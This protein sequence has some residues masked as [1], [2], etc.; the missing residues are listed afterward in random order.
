MDGSQCDSSSTFPVL[1]VEDN[2]PI[3]SLLQNALEGAGH[4]SLCVTNGPDALA[5]LEQGY[6]PIV[7]TDLVV[8]GMD[9]LELCR[10]IRER[11]Q[12][13]YIYII[14]LTARGSREDLI[15]GLEAGADEYLVKPLG[16]AELRARLKI[17]RR[18][19]D[20]ESSLKKSLEEFKNL[21][22]KDS[23]TGFFNRRYLAER[24]P[25]EIRRAV[26]YGRPLSLLLFDLDHFK[27]VND[28][29]GH[30]VGDLLL[31]QCGVSVV[32]ALRHDLDW[33]VRYGGEEFLVVLPETDLDGALV[34]AERLRSSLAQFDISTPQG[35]VRTTASFGVASLPETSTRQRLAA[36]A[37]IECADRCLYEAKREGRNRV[38]GQRA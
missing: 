8:S 14:V 9:G 35:P 19:L 1:V 34:V 33:A 4:A 2:P 37:L 22:V 5:Q 12:K 11:F 18:I 15:E 21:S 32:D 27:R 7:I 30:Q 13:Y 28:Q 6:F 3:C 23:L 38:K 20:L 36:E 25:Q 29:F 17:A 24:L 31:Q 26:R 10:T 16:E